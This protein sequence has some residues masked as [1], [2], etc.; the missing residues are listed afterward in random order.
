ENKRTEPGLNVCFIWDI[1]VILNLVSS[2]FLVSP[3]APGSAPDPAVVSSLVGTDVL[4]PCPCPALSRPSEPHVQWCLDS[5]GPVLEQRGQQKWTAEELSERAELPQSGRGD[6]SLRLRDLQVSDGGQYQSFLISESERGDFLCSVKLLVFDHS[7]VQFK[8]PGEDLILD[9][10]TPHAMSL[11]FQGSNSSEWRPLWRRGGP[12]SPRVVKEPLKEQLRLTSVSDSDE[13]VYK[14]LDQNGL[15]VSSTRLSL[16]Q[17]ESDALPAP[18]RGA[19]NSTG[20]SHASSS[21]VLDESTAL[22]FTHR[23][24]LFLRA[25]AVRSSCCTLPLLLLLF[26]LTSSRLVL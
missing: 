25:A 17:G 16:D 20:S 23:D 15:T 7:S 1:L 3:A 14:V 6:C 13:G 24:Q 11:A 2:A 12:A 8:R 19:F 5:V 9:L 4:L 10:H 26:I 18:D 22:R 21:C